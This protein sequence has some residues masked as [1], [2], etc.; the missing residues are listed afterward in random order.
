VSQCQKEV[1]TNKS[2]GLIIREGEHTGRK[3]DTPIQ[4]FFVKIILQASLNPVLGIGA[5]FHAVED[6][7]GTTPYLIADSWILGDGVRRLR[8]DQEAP[9]TNSFRG[10]IIQAET[11]CCITQDRENRSAPGKL[12][13]CSS[14][15]AAGSSQE[16]L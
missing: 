15:V 9:L 11:R 12:G 5:G 13:Y 3:E 16:D 2:I 4:Y 1:R 7:S 14:N 10:V 6:G 8:R